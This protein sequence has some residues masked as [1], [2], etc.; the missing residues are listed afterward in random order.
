MSKDEGSGDRGRWNA[1]IA[2]AAM[3]FFLGTVGS[4]RAEETSMLQS[5]RRAEAGDAASQFRVGTAYSTG[6]GLVRDE[7]KAARWFLSAAEQGHPQAQYL[8]G[9]LYSTG[10]GLPQDV[11]LAHKWL[12]LAAIRSEGEDRELALNVRNGITVRMTPDEIQEAHR[13]AD[14]WTK[15]HP[16][17]GR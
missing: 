2:V 1:W 13:L 9:L 10:M 4:S 5:L 3:A 17:T 15:A 16:L 14:A 11:V 12:H 6:E 7:A 8:L